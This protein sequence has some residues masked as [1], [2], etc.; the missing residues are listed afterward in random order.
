MKS[1]VLY[2]HSKDVTLNIKTLHTEAPVISAIHDFLTHDEAEYLIKKAESLG[3]TRSTVIG[4]DG[5]NRSNNTRTSTTA[6]IPKNDD[7]V[8]SCIEN[9][10]SVAA[11]LPKEY[12]EPLQVTRYQHKEKYNSHY[13]WFQHKNEETGQRTKTVFT[14]L[15]GLEN[16]GGKFCGGATA[17][18]KLKNENNEMLREYPVSGNA[19]MWSNVKADG[20]GDENTLH[21]GEPV[22]CEGTTK[23]GLN[24]WFRNIPY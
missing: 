22:L 7:D 12:L 23:I 1:C 14:Y 2:P 6:F 8:I 5:V 17:F 15:K 24:A 9:K 21:G 19:V 13:D 10:I 11:G 4:T 18:P 16:D 20:S 3:M